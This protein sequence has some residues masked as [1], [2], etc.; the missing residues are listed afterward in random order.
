MF[1]SRFSGSLFNG[2]PASLN[3]VYL[4][5]LLCFVSKDFNTLWGFLWQNLESFFLLALNCCAAIPAGAAGQAVLSSLVWGVPVGVT[6]HW[7]WLSQG[8]R[9]RSPW[10]IPLCVEQTRCSSCW[11]SPCVWHYIAVARAQYSLLTL[12]AAD[13]LLFH[14]CVELAWRKD[15]L[16]LNHFIL[17][18]YALGKEPQ[19]TRS[20][21]WDFSLLFISFNWKLCATSL[22]PGQ[23]LC[24]PWEHRG[25]PQS[26]GFRGTNINRTLSASQREKGVIAKQRNLALSL[27]C[28]LQGC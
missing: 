1:D 7:S 26:R 24:L 20:F 19:M 13:V 25:Y 12:C 21:V 23:W 8:S 5:L 11:L 14:S 2:A 18:L 10:V 6:A 22:A 17:V 15:V 9:F 28:F 4:W 16:F 3:L 27:F